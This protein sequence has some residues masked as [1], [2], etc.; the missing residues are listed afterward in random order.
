MVWPEEKPIFL[1][2]SAEDHAQGGIT[3]DESILLIKKLRS[4]GIDF[5]DVSAGSIIPGEEVNVF[6]G[7]Q[8]R[9]SET[10]RK[11][12]GIPTGAIGSIT[13]SE[14]VDEI[15]SS[16]RADLVFMGREL[17]RNPFWVWETAK[18]LNV[19][20]ELPISTYSRATDPYQRG[21]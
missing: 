10:I 4:M 11:E 2:I 6:P 19:D 14:H 20:I 18:K 16:G 3:L 21:H 17:L 12:V 7:Y 5:L 1:R 15:L 8:V 9:Y 13:S